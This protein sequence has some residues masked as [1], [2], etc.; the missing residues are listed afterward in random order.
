MDINIAN[1][2][3]SGYTCNSILNRPK[4]KPKTEAPAPEPQPAKEG[5]AQKDNMDVD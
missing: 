2:Y 4:P 1:T 5:D 3:Y